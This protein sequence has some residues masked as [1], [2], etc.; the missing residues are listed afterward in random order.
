MRSCS[1]LG[2]RSAL[3]RALAF[4]ATLDDCMIAA[5]VSRFTLFF[6]PCSPPPG[7]SFTSIWVVEE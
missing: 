7:A 6:C 1:S 5:S 4:S 2:V 3:R